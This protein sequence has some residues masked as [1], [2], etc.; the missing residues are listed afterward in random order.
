[1]SPRIP[2]PVLVGTVALLGLAACGGDGGAPAPTPARRGD[3]VVAAP[4]KQVDLGEFCEQHPEPAA[5]KTL[6][7]PTLD[8]AR[9]ARATG[10]S[11]V[12]VWATWCGP[13]IE[14]MPRLERWKSRLAAEGMDVALHFLSVD[15]KA[16]DVRL[17]HERNPASPTGVRMAKFEDLEGWLAQIG[18]DATSVLPI[19]LFV[20][21]GERIRCVRMG[22]VGETD[23][24]T[25]KRVFAGG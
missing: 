22:S 8:E 2:S 17:F 23:Y 10:W 13:C 12:N 9:P 20:D 18:L 1:V 3:G 24:D 4:Q 7:W 6:V 16:E 14:E 5:A 25:V 15:A 19:H 21:P 11:W